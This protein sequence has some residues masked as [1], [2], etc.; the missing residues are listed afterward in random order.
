MT[1]SYGIHVA[2]IYTLL[3]YVNIVFIYIA[4][5]RQIQA[6]VDKKK[7]LLGI[8]LMFCCV[9]AKGVEHKLDGLEAAVDKVCDVCGKL[10]FLPVRLN[11]NVS[12][13]RIRDMIEIV[14]KIKFPPSY[15]FVTVYFTGHWKKGSI[16]TADGEMSIRDIVMPFHQDT[17]PDM[18]NR[19]NFFVFDCCR[20]V[21]SSCRESAKDYMRIENCYFLFA[22]TPNHFAY[23]T[24]TSTS[25]GEKKRCGRLTDIFVRLMHTENKPFLKLA[26]MARLE[27][28]ELSKNEEIKQVVDYHENTAVRKTVCLLK[29]S[30]GICK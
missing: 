21:D 30:V 10:G 2:G 5:T 19:I 14:T 17:C 20:T 1:I 25:T 26:Y 12:S 8:V 28:N 16:C 3:S 11:E 24:E 6:K 13:R 22:T 7:N 4:E 9:D 23:Y 18:R 29:E 15:R 27:I